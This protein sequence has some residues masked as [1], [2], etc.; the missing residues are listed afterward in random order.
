MTAKV[1]VMLKLEKLE[2]TIKYQIS[3]QFNFITRA[4]SKTTMGVL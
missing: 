4:L 1:I 2:C 3:A